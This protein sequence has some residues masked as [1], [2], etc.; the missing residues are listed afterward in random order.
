M[1]LIDVAIDFISSFVPP[2]MPYRTGRLLNE[3]WGTTPL[4]PLG[5]NSI[6]FN[7]C[8]DPALQYGIILNEAPIIN[9]NLR[10]RSGSYVNKHYN[11]FDK[12]FDNFA[13]KLALKLGGELIQGEL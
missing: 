10:G 3:S 5:K 11:Y 1:D 13:S 9:Y 12:Y 8:E 2:K 7:F 6:G 4:T